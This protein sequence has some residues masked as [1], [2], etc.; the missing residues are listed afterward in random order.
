[1]IGVKLTAG[2]HEVVFT[3]HNAAFSLGWKVS[4]ACVMAFGV[5][6]FVFYPVRRRKGKFEQA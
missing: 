2:S 6:I 1:M 5:I 4:L 3:Y